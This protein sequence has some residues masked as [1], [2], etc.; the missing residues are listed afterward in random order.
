MATAKKAA[1]KTAAKKPAKKAGKKT[2]APVVNPW[3]IAAWMDWPG[4]TTIV[5]D[6]HADAAV[7]ELS[8]IPSP[9]AHAAMTSLRMHTPTCSEEM[10][11]EQESGS[12]QGHPHPN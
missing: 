6:V 10:P 1:K 4:P 2:A 7:P 5:S 8:A 3:L 9:A 11:G 12:P